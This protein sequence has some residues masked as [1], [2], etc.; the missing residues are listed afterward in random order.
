MESIRMELRAD[1]QSQA[2]TIMAKALQDCP[3]S[4]LLWSEAIFMEPRP[5]RKSKSVDA[6]KKCE[7][8]GR[9]VTTVARLFWS[10]RNIDKARSWFDR[11]VKLQPNLGDSWA[12]YYKFLLQH[13]TA[14]QRDQLVQ[15]CT[16]A[17]PHHGEVWARIAKEPTNWRRSTKELLA[18]VAKEVVGI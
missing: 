14:E 12:T 8:D 17:E 15:R 3:T 18:L 10:E 1:N 5:A 9:V 16:N 11:A 6:I 7:G 4:G 2:R 13:G